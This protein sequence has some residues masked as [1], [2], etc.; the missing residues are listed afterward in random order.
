VLEYFCTES[1]SAY[2]AF[3]NIFRKYDLNRTYSNLFENNDNKT[4]DINFETLTVLL[5]RLTPEQPAINNLIQKYCGSVDSEYYYFSAGILA[6]SAVVAGIYYLYHKMETQY[7]NYNKSL[8]VNSII[9]L[10]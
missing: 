10:D 7:Q 3:L 5:N 2:K 9:Y 1:D 4:S 8:G 6:G